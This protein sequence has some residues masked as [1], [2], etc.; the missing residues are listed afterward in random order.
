MSRKENIVPI[1]E[2]EYQKH[3]ISE[4]K[5]NNDGIKKMHIVT[6]GCSQNISDSEKLKGMLHDMGYVWTEDKK[7][8]HIIIF[9]TCAVREN[10]EFKVYGNIGAL[11]NI[12]KNKPELIIGVC[13]CMMQQP[14]VIDQIKKKYKHVDLVFGTHNIYKFPQYL[15][16]SMITNNTL[17][18]VMDIDGQIFEN[19]P[20]LREN[21]VRA[22]VPIMSGCNNFCAYCIVPFVRGRERS[23]EPSQIIDEIKKLEE[24]GYIEVTLL[25]QNVNSYGQGLDENIDFAD[26]LQ[27]VCRID[28]IERVRFMTSHPKDISD[29]LISIIANNTKICRQLHLPFQA[30]SNK[31][32]KMMNRKYT[33]EDYL[34]KI[35]KVKK[36]IPDIAISTDIIVGFP[37]ETTEDFEETLDIV[38][39]VRFDQVFMFIYS[40]RYGTPAEK[41]EDVIDEKQKKENFGLLLDLQNGINREIN[42]T[43]VGKTVEI[44]VE[45]KSKND[46]NMLTGRTSHSK[47][48]NFKGNDEL[49]NKIVNVK[50]NKALSFHLMGEAIE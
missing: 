21:N 19:L 22:N 49:I 14:H 36:L 30:G 8:A 24:E 37:G 10:A 41:M 26:L 38:R 11:K 25:G 40:K 13:G 44:L 18:N 47:V 3:I 43:Y 4:I 16:E 46:K 35:E 1:E 12:K 15:K 39:N 50:I 31:V 9:N 28:G 2:I 34:T 23:R 42:E 45:G 20:V 27:M 5:L 32:L 33:K 29:K 7:E 48:V 17:I 6:Y